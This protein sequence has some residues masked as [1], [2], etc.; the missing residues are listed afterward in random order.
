MPERRRVF[1][2]SAND[3]YDRT[4]NFHQSRDSSGL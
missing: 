4:R 1:G 2:E 3:L